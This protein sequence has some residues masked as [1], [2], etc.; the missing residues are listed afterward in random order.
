MW[1]RC[2]SSIVSLLPVCGVQPCS[3]TKA[4]IR[5]SMLFQSMHAQQ[6]PGLQIRGLRDLATSHGSEQCSIKV[7]I[8]PYTGRMEEESLRWGRDLHEGSED[9]WSKL[10]HGFKGSPDVLVDDIH[11]A[12]R[13]ILPCTLFLSILY[14]DGS[15]LPCKLRHSDRESSGAMPIPKLPSL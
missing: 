15:L 2:K 10:L 5:S 1:Q 8:S 7:S 6:T 11:I 4:L 9:L 14:V 3:V 13:Q 12:I